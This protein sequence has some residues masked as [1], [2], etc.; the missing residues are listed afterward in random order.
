MKTGGS[1][2]ASEM[3]GNELLS[4]LVLFPA[5]HWFHNSA[6]E[7]KAMFGESFNHA[8][9]LTWVRNPFARVVSSFF[10]TLLCVILPPTHASTRRSNYIGKC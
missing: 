7:Q 10:F 4:E 5:Q 3:Y 8:L 1:S 9:H 2:V 6:Y